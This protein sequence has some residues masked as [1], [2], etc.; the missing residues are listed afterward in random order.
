LGS[1]GGPITKDNTSVEYYC[2]IFALAESAV[3]QGVLWAGSDDGLVHVTRDGG[4]NW[5]NVTPK[6]V[7]GGR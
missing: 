1:S 2:T 6:D 7:P 4:K 3:Q 5:T